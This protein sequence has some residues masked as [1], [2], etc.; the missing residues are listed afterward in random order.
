MHVISHRHTISIY[1]YFYEAEHVDISME[2]LGGGN[3]AQLRERTA[4]EE[5]GLTSL[6]VQTC[7]GMEAAP[8]Q[9]V[10]HPGHKPQNILTGENGAVRIDNAGVT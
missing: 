4:F 9:G 2:Y 8:D 6:M 10:M 7:L 5:A 3:L 1:E